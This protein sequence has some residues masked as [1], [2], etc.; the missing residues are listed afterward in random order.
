MC[1]KYRVIIKKNLISKFVCVDTSVG[2]LFVLD[3]IIHPVVRV[4][5]YVFSYI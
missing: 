5:V 4:F 3:C 1:T 2:G